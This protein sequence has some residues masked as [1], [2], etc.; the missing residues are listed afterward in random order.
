MLQHNRA[1]HQK[2]NWLVLTNAG[3]AEVNNRATMGALDGLTNILH[4]RRGN[5][6]LVELQSPANAP[7]WF[8]VYDKS[9][10][11]VAY[12][13]VN[14]AAVQDQ[15]LINRSNL[16]STRVTDQINAEHLYENA[17]EYA[18]K[19]D[20]KI[21]NGNGFRIVTIANALQR[22][23]PTTA[24][25]AFE[26]HDHYCPGVTSGVIMAEYIKKYFP[27]APDTR[28][29]I[30]AIQPW[31]KEDALMVL[32]N[33]TPGKKSYSATYPSQEDIASWPIWAQKVS[34]V[35]YRYNK[36]TELW[37][38]LALEYLWGET[39]CPDYGHSVMNKLCADLWYLDHMD[40]PESFVRVL[41]R[42]NLPQGSHPKEYARPGVDPTFLLGYW[43]ELNP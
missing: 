43:E 21:F 31:C 13:E 32:L 26:I 35:V 8:A 4:V 28:Y 16:F 7:L 6:S 20:N 40:Q 38:G 9:S 12:L 3:Y 29:F 25:R 5:H 2:N 17:A 36:E 11:W 23:A 15:T 34:T 19:F 1:H 42:F 33:A 37:E 22:G 30:Q 24:L 41:K 10:G 14:P 39:N 18:E 27:T